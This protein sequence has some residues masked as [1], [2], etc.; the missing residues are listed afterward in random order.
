MF[1]NEHKWRK[2]TTHKTPVNLNNRTDLK[3]V[4]LEQVVQYTRRLNRAVLD[5][6][7]FKSFPFRKINVPYITFILPF[8]SHN[9]KDP[10]LIYNS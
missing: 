3:A 4:R 1:E 8:Y 7:L 5:S 9:Q 6:T 2:V 10:E